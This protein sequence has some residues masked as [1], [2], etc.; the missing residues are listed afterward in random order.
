MV[1]VGCQQDACGNALIVD[2]GAARP[3]PG[4]LTRMHRK[5]TG[6][7]EVL[8]QRWLAP[9]ALEPG[10]H[11]LVIPPNPYNT[12]QASAEFRCAAGDLVYA[13]IEI[14]SGDTSQAWRHWKTQV[15]GS[16]HV[17]TRSPEAF[18]EQP[19]LIWRA[20]EWLVP[21]ESGR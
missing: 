5:P 11:R 6:G 12:L 9:V 21:Q 2:D 13:A 4:V 16:I 3:L 18:R 15:H 20:G 19:M 7:V 17:S 8:T 10:P 14:V 1:I